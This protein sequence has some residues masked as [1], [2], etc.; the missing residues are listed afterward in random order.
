MPSLRDEHR[1]KKHAKRA[2]KLKILKK[3]VKH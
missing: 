1:I 2:L 3:I